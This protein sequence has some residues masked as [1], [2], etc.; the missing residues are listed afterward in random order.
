LANAQE[1][2]QTLDA[3]LVEYYHH[4]EGWCAFI[5]TTANFMCVPLPFIT[6]DFLEQMI[7]WTNWI[8]SGD[9]CD[10]PIL[11]GKP[12]YDLHAA[13]IAPIRAYLPTGGKV[14][15]A[16][17]WV[18][19]LLPLSAARNPH[20]NR[21]V[22]EDYQLAF[23]PSISALWVMYQ[24]A[25]RVHDKEETSQNR[26]PGSYHLLNAAYVHS[27]GHP[28]YRYGAV[29]ANRFL[30]QSFAPHITGLYNTNA[31]PD[32]V[33]AAVQQEPVKT[34]LHITAHGGFDWDMPE[35]SGLELAEGYL[36]VQRIISEMHLSQTQLVTLASCLLGQA[37]LEQ[38]GEAVG[39]TQAF[40]TAG[41]KSVVTALWSV[42]V[43]ATNALFQAFYQQIRA[44][45][46][47]AVAMREAMAEIRNTPG[48]EHPYYWAAW[49]V[50]GLAF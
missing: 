49:Q 16:T 28:G 19:N 1:L 6:D 46:P 50:Y 3:T 2:A 18:L 38:S 10:S 14:I 31:T 4:A 34:I 21:Y 20:T 12:L 13:V 11:M 9:F 44:G 39:I 43:K 23:A 24:Q 29:D 32:A 37:S 45:Y 36:T 22:C 8:E 7:N 17:H 40:L 33:I 30:A 26:Q 5:V 42:N 47:P 35:Q 25:S 15:L 41:A 48:W 27:P